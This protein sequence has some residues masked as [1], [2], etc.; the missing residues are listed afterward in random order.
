MHSLLSNY[1]KCGKEFSIPYQNSFWSR[2]EWRQTTKLAKRHQTS[3]TLDNRQDVGHPTSN[4]RQDAGHRKSEKTRDIRHL[5]SDKP[6]HIQ[7]L[8]MRQVVGHQTS[9]IE[10]DALPR[11]SDNRQDV[12]HRIL[13]IKQTSNIG[14]DVRCN[15]KYQSSDMGHQTK[16][17]S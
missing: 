2:T 16:S 13:D 15:K 12:G 17:C 1:I 6:S 14:Q 7:K 5:A 10:Q 8:D 4:I 11:I 3:R 9:Q